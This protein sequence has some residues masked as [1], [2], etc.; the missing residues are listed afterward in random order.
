MSSLIARVLHG[1]PQATQDEPMH[2]AI[3]AAAQAPL[4][5]Y[6][7][8]AKGHF[9]ALRYNNR[10]MKGLFFTLGLVVATAASAA[11]MNSVGN[12]VTAY[13]T[14]TSHDISGLRT[15]FNQFS[16]S[17][18]GTGSCKTFPFNRASQLANL[19]AF[20]CF[21]YSAQSDSGEQSKRLKNVAGSNGSCGWVGQGNAT[22]ALI[23]VNSPYQLNVPTP[24]GAKEDPSLG[25]AGVQIALSG[26]SDV[27]N[28]V[29][30]VSATSKGV[31]IAAR[32]AL[33]TSPPNTIVR[34]CQPDAL[35]SST[36]DIQTRLQRME[37]GRA[38]SSDTDPSDYL[39]PGKNIGRFGPSITRITVQDVTVCQGQS[40]VMRNVVAHERFAGPTPGS[41]FDFTYAYVMQKTDKW[42]VQ[43]WGPV[44]GQDQ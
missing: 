32:G 12:S 17:C 39:M 23:Q 1:P 22:P 7:D 28:F 24:D 30:P 26:Q 21:T 8:E 40:D 5:Q 3:T 37:T 11:Y 42:Y 20:E 14:D 34:S 13:R 25:L 10:F 19:Y 41:S 43:S 38:N 18:A 2:K 9:T 31:N 33:Y 35:F 27:M 36:T 4:D 29:V 16:A 15:D 44:L 6:E